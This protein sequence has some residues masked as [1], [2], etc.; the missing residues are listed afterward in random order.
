MGERPMATQ[1]LPIADGTIFS[2]KNDNVVFIGGYWQ[3]ACNFV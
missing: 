3:V 1:E 2:L